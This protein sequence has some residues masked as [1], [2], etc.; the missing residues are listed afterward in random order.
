MLPI[1]S[2]DV[3]IVEFTYCVV[4]VV[5]LYWRLFCWC[6]LVG[7]GFDDVFVLVFTGVMV[8]CY[9]GVF[10][11]ALGRECAVLWGGLRMN[12]VVLVFE[13]VVKV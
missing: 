6:L 7:Y 5:L 12:C 11:I 4:G 10:C 2:R 8:Y 1:V 9:C 13:I 3:V